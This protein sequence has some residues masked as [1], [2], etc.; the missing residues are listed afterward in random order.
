MDENAEVEETGDDADGNNLIKSMRK[1]L[2]KAQA[3]AKRLAE[4][5]QLFQESRA[6]ARETQIANAVNGKGYPES[7]VAALK[8]QADSASDDEFNALIQ[9]LGVSAETPEGEQQEATPPTQPS[10]ADLGQRVAAAATGQAG[11]VDVMKKIASTNSRE[12]LLAIVS[13]LGLDNF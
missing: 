1:E 10:P 13:E 5:N 3:E 2:A 8:A 12:E 6:Q 9:D 4:E 11:E 7:I